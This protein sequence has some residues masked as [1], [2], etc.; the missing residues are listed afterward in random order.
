[1]K[2]ISKTRISRDMI[3]W[4]EWNFFI[5]TR[6]PEVFFSEDNCIAGAGNQLYS[7][8]EEYIEGVLYR[9]DRCYFPLPCKKPHVSFNPD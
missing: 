2:E 5:L 4:K 8:K 1:M 9:N 6:I 7:W 3:L